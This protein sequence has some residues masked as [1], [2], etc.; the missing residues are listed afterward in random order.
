MRINLKEKI[1]KVNKFL[2]IKKLVGNRERKG[3]G[4]VAGDHEIEI[5]RKWVGF[6][7]CEKQ[8]RKSQK[9]KS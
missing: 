7:A 1:I 8:K 6:G 3:E 5:K 9:T 2:L 4:G